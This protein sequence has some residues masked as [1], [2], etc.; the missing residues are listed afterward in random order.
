MSD[1]GQL[2]TSAV[3]EPAAA[4]SPWRRWSAEPGCDAA[5]AIAAAPRLPL[6]VVS[7]QT[8]AERGGAEYA[9]VDMLDALAD[10]GAQATLLTNLP[11]LADGT[12][13]TVRPIDLGPK[14]GRRS[15]ARVAAGMLPWTVRLRRALRR[16]AAAAP[17]D[18]TLLHFKKEQFMTPL[19]SRRVAGRIVWAEWGPLPGP[20]TRAPFRQ[21]Y[22]L[23]ARSADHI[24][25]V[26][27]NTADSLHA[28]GI[29]A[30]R[31]T[32]VPP[33]VP[34]HRLRFDPLK[35]ARQRAEWGASDGTFVIGCVSRLSNSKRVDVLIDA[36][37]HLD[38]DV[39]VVVGGSGEALPRLQAAAAAHPG[40]VRFEPSVRGR[41]VEVL[42]ACDVQVFA[43]QPQEGLPRSLALGML[44]ERPIVATADN[45]T[46][47]LLAPEAIV[48]PAHDPAALARTLDAYRAD[49]ARRRR[50]G[51]ALRRRALERFDPDTTVATITRG[52][53]GSSAVARAGA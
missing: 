5:D 3:S 12:G 48:S 45:G 36:L 7:V 40:R 20:L 11:D 25:A 43:P 1:S 13:V 29:P 42:S 53:T 50:E 47:G 52:L 9:N 35:R 26:S 51:A 39:L 17:I 24:L 34:A 33:V 19:L 31:I 32:V 18:C 49:P 4:Q 8:T 27:E 37:D 6:H 44:M 28:I 23:A 16:E 22:R 30:D 15:L 2:Q 41:V 38:G 14:L 46:A 21:I 10:R